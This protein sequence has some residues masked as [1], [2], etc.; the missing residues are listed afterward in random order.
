MKKIDVEWKVEFILEQYA[1]IREQGIERAFIGKY[2]DC[3]DQGMY[4]CI[5]CGAEF[6][7]S[8]DKFDSGSGWSSFVQL[9]DA[10]RVEEERDASYGMV[11]VEVY[12]KECGAHLEHIFPDNP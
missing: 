5:C 6:F 8:D 3:H 2:W 9:A 1:V 12:C 7:K 4:A 10:S 11:R